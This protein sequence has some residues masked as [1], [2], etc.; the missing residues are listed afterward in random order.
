MNE[1]KMQAICRVAC[2]FVN[3]SGALMMAFINFEI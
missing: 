2:R 3:T 1:T